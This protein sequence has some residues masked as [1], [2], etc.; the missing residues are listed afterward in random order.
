M[1]EISKYSLFMACC[2]LKECS[3]GKTYAINKSLSQTVFCVDG[4]YS[5]FKTR[6]CRFFPCSVYMFSKFV[7]EGWQEVSGCN[8]GLQE[9]EEGEQVGAT[10]DCNER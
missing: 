9:E 7:P 3:S 1:Y 8:G 5:V 6:R 4:A 10:L 2:P